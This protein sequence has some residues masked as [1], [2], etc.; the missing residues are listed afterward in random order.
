VGDRL[1]YTYDFGDA[2]GHEAV[3]EERVEEAIACP[4]VVAGARA[5]PP[6]DC[7]GL[8]GYERIVALI[9]VG[10]ERPGG[11]QTLARAWGSGGRDQELSEWLE[12]VHPGWTPEAFDLASINRRLNRP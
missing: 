10:E 12:A 8:P 11:R 5:C 1:R 2:W 3:V 6:E 7:G 4:R 9:R